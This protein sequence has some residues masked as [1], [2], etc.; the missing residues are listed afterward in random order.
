MDYVPF[1]TNTDFREVVASVIVPVVAHTQNIDVHK[2]TID[3]FAAVFD[4]MLQHI[5]LEAWLTQE[6]ARQRQKTLQNK[7]GDFH[8]RLIGKLA[9][10]QSLGTGHI[11][12]IHCAAKRFVAEVKNKYNTTKGNHKKQIY[13]DLAAALAS[14]Q[15]QNHVG[16][17]VE[18]IP[19]TGQR[20]DEVFTPPDNL[21]SQRR[22]S[23]ENIRRIDGYSFY[24]LV[25]DIPDALQQVYEAL[26]RVIGDILELPP[27]LIQRIYED[28][29]ISDLF[30]RAYR[31]D[32]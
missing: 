15:Y 11:I 9:D 26:P 14:P 4:A 21:S 7:I 13:D 22:P 12:D 30:T 5:T 32:A 3:P 24:T 2:N 25:T 6:H 16:Y 20:Y 27:S 8:Q 28:D 23:N 1:I 31:I 10:C 17:Y 29:H 19:K 18:I